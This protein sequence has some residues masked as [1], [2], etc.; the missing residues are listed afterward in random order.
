M[1]IGIF[2]REGQRIVIENVKIEEEMCDVVDRVSCGDA[3]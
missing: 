3:L 2:D 1:A